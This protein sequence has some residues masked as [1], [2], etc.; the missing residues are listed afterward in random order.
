LIKIILGD[1]TERLIMNTKDMSRE[2]ISALADGELVDQQID[3]ALAVLRKPEEQVTWDL[4]HQI[5]DV[6]RS[7]EMGLFPER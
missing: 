4:Y 7:D 2:Q 3:I 6:L 1:G 5:G